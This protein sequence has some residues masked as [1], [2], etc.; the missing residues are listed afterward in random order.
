MFSL[1]GRLSGRTLVENK[2]TLLRRPDPT[3]QITNSSNRPLK[4]GRSPDV[5][6]WRRFWV[7][8]GFWYA[9]HKLQGYVRILFRRKGIITYLD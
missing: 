1:K 4:K 7:C 5:L 3:Y 9:C 8:L 6:E 2:S